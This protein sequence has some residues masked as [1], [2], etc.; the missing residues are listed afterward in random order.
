MLSSFKIDNIVFSVIV[1]FFHFCFV[2]YCGHSWNKPWLTVAV[3]VVRKYI[4]S[5]LLYTHP[6]SSFVFKFDI[7]K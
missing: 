2:V 4:L 5:S 7:Y 1:N 6:N 3:E